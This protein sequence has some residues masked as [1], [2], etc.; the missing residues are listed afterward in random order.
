MNVDLRTIGDRQEIA[1]LLARIAHLADAGDPAEYVR[2]FTPDAVWDLTDATDLPMDVQ[3]ISGRAAL[4]AGVHERR[5]A[6]IQGPGTHTRHDVSSIAVEV[7]GDRARSRAYF[8][9]YRGTD[10]APVLAAMGVYA[11]EFVRDGDRWLLRRRVIS[12]G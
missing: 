2:C 9:Y 3:T 10:G 12:R 8:R 7:D 1:M 6:G 11:D 4:L 5:A